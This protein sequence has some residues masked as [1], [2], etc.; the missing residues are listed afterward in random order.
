MALF[1]TFG[2]IPSG[3]LLTNISG[4]AQYSSGIFRN[5]HD[6]PMMSPDTSYLKLTWS[7]LNKPRNTAPPKPIPSVKTNLKE[8]ESGTPVLVWFGHSSYLLRINGFNILVDPVFCGY[9]SPF[10]FFGSC[11]AGSNVYTVE[12]MPEIDILVITHDHYDHMDFDT[13]MKLQPKTKSIITSLGVGSHLQYWGI[14]ANKITELDWWQSTEIVPG[15]KFTATPARHFSGRGF[16]RA[17]TFWSSFVLQ[18]AEYKIYL[19]GDSGYDSH[20]KEIG[21]RYGPFDLAI[22]ENGQYDLKWK[23]IHM[24]PEEVVQA[25]VDLKAK[26]LLPVHWGK[27]ALALHAWDDPIERVCKTAG[28]MG[29][30]ITTPMIGEPVVINHNYPNKKWWIL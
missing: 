11:F 28:D 19:G 17:K 5:L 3:K 4:S 13:V 23:Y 12:D 21:E 20:F 29:Q 27:F 18:A 9:A 2:K 24:L 10:S 14:D 22:L 6:T 15:V 8:L 1:K 25:A 26:V 7:F 30:L 16:T